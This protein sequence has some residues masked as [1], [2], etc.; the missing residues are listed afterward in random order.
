LTDWFCKEV[1]HPSTGSTGTKG[2]R[3]IGF[4]SRKEIFGLE[5]SSFEGNKKLEVTRNV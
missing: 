1:D 3:Q 4:V 2:Q 5:A